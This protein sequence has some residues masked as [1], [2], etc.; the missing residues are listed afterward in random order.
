MRNSRK[1]SKALSPEARERVMTALA[2]KAAEGNATAAKI[3]FEECRAQAQGESK[4][5]AANFAVLDAAFERWAKGA[6]ADE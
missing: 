6:Q 5:G 4:T 3:Y 2:I 1:K